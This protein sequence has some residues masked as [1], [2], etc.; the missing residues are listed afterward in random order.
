MI[1][2]NYKYMYVCT[3]TILQLMSLG[4]VNSYKTIFR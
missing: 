1:Y 2:N 3:V 4:K